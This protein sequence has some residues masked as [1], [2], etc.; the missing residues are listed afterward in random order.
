MQM[1][2]ANGC[3]VLD[4]FP[5]MD[6]ANF[7]TN[8]DILRHQFSHADLQIQVCR[9]KCFLHTH[10]DGIDNLDIYLIP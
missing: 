1:M 2:V 7:V 9:L 10:L 4:G 6:S 3:H 8:N 5:C